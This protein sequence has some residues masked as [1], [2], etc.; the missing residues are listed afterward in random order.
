MPGHVCHVITR[1]DALGGAQM[2]VYYLARALRARGWEVTVVGDGEGSFARMLRQEGV[3]CIALPE[4]VHPVRPRADARALA[5][6]TA[7]L[8]ALRPDLV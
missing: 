8:R 2:H 6:L 4:L 5:V 7:T 1:L 3:P